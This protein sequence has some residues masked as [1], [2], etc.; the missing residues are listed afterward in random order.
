MAKFYYT[1]VS[2]SA[3]K[4]LAGS[5]FAENEKE[6]R[7]ILNKI[8][9]AILSI[10]GEKLIEWDD[11]KAFEFEVVSKLNEKFKG[12][13]LA[14]NEGEIFDRLAEEFEFKSINYIYSSNASEGE[15][16][17]AREKSVKE[18][19]VKK[20]KKEAAEEEAEKR[21]LTG[22]LKALAKMGKEE[23]FDQHAENLKKF[24]SENE[25]DLTKKT[26]ADVADPDKPEAQQIKKVNLVEKAGDS[27]EEKDEV[28]S[29]TEG[30]LQ[31]LKNKFT[32][33]FPEFSE[34][35]GK[36][37]F[38]FTEIVVPQK[39]MTRMD[40]L[41]NMRKFLFP[42]KSKKELSQIQQKESE[43]TMRRKAA[44]ERF[45]IS[46]E[47]IVDVLAA[48][49]LAYF[50]F[51]MLALYIDVPRVSDLAEQTLRG[52]FIIPFLA[53]TFIFLRF[54]IL[55]REKFTSWSLIRT[56]ILFLV[57][58]VMIIFAGMNLL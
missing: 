23:E 46:L 58:G 10:A 40:G 15:K 11:T 48:V 19:I 4:R 22:G 43:V 50:A 9:M 17:R 44:T 16:M 49:F 2:N 47:E 35:A 55:L 13:M 3:K 26:A 27:V 7:A 8:G 1:A 5:V 25:E 37:Y 20:Q 6:A 41:V 52:N 53:G 12:E 29:T 56:L 51:G 54:L 33:F 31:K 38:L 34:K 14:E 39:D 18:I 30:K 28:G 32:D 36:F 42:Q 24:S 57:G 45:W 21:T